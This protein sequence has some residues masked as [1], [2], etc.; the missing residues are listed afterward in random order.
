MQ[1]IYKK[2][3][4]TCREEIYVFVFEGI[5]NNHEKNNYIFVLVPTKPT[6]ELLKRKDQGM[7]KREATR[8]MNEAHLG[9]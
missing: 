9:Y 6:T 1:R 4:F 3:E 8:A 7:Y 5:L 2:T